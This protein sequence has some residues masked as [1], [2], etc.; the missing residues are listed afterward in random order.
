MNFFLYWTDE[1][2]CVFFNEIRFKS[3]FLS[4]RSVVGE[5]DDDDE[6]EEEEEPVEADDTDDDDDLFGLGGGDDA[7]DDEPEALAAE[8][9]E[10]TDA[11][12][13]DGAFGIFGGDLFD[14]L[15][16]DDTTTKKPKVK[17]VAVCNVKMILLTWWFNWFICMRT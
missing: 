17:P 6:E 8:A 4:S 7:D 16:E 9:V 14:A 5:D 15:F 3:N 1:I 12:A 2:N 13:D 10:D 11:D